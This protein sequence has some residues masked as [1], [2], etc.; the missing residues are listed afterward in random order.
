MADDETE[1]TPLERTATGPRTLQGK[2]RSK[3]NALKHGIFSNVM[4]LANESKTEFDSLLNGLREDFQPDGMIEGVLVEKLATLLWR[5]RRLIIA[6]GAEIQGDVKGLEWDRQTEQFDEAEELEKPPPPRALPKVGEPEGYVRLIGKIRNPYVLEKCL[7]GLAKLRSQ[8]AARGFSEDSDLKMLIYIYGP[9]TYRPVRETIFDSYGTW[10]NTAAA[11]KKKPQPDGTPT[12]AE[13]L[14]NVL[15]A[16]DAEI[17]RF[18]NL[19]KEYAVVEA[20]RAKQDA[21]RRDVP[22]SA[23]ADRLLRYEASIERSFDRTLK[24]LERIRRARLGLPVPPSV[25]VNVST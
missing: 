1:L 6:E 2:E 8:I 13:C 18:Q 21:L 9:R 25:D 5:H 15:R 3:H 4:L 23:G 14:Q 20:S 10:A 11:W 24:Q 16:I 7:A 22:D 12:P 17:L 19:Q